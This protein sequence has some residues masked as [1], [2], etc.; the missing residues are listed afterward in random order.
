ME[1]E[2]IRYCFYCDKQIQFEDERED[3][4]YRC[5]RCRM[6]CCQDC[7]GVDTKLCPECDEELSWD[8]A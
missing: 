8:E 1:I 5:P 6:L 3:A 2:V 4:A 7:L